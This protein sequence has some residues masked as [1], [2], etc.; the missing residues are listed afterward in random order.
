MYSS[1]MSPWIYF[2]VSKE[3]YIFLYNSYGNK[4][5]NPSFIV[6]NSFEVDGISAYNNNSNNFEGLVA[7]Y[8][9]NIDNLELV[10]ASY[11]D[12]Y[13]IEFRRIETASDHAKWFNI[14]YN[15]CFYNN[16][17]ILF[18]HESNTIVNPFFDAHFNQ[19]IKYPTNS[20]WV[21]AQ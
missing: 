5:Y 6:S 7:E 10:R 15:T 13:L 8:G 17:K 14:D 4:E 11:T 16:I 20:S 21:T 19:L 2:R 1:L 18:M 3:K 12:G 9:V